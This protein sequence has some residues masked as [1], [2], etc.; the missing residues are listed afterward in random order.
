[1]LSAAFEIAVAE[2]LEIDQPQTDRQQPE[3]KQSRQGVEPDS[4]AV[5]RGARRHFQSS[6]TFGGPEEPPRKTCSAGALAR[7]LSVVV[8]CGDGAMP[9]SR[10]ARGPSPRNHIPSVRISPRPE[11]RW[12]SLEHHHRRQRPC[13]LPAR[14]AAIACPA[15]APSHQFALDRAA[16]PLPG[17]AP[18]S[19]P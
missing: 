7:V 9:R 15:C 11:S 4:C 16:T 8:S 5:R 13:E 6:E 10:R 3:A 17:A 12:P 1:M 18:G 2:N 19:F 14:A